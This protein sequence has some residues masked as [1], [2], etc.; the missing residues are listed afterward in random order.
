MQAE[1]FNQ[2]STVRFWMVI[3]GCHWT[4]PDKHLQC[5]GDA[6][7]LRDGFQPQPHLRHRPL[8][9]RDDV[10]SCTST[11]PTQS[12]SFAWSHSLVCGF[13]AAACCHTSLPCQGKIIVQSSQ[14]APKWCTSQISQFVTVKVMTASPS[15]HMCFDVKASIFPYPPSQ[16]YPDSSA[17]KVEAFP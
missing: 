8:V 14:S 13:L 15:M 11:S 3:A 5:I 2:F 4:H 10:V 16:H 1:H 17:Y 7:L 12:A 9:H 6:V